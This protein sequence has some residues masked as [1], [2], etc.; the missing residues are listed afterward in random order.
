[1]D[2]D[3]IEQGVRL[4]LEGIGE[5]AG[6]EGLLDTP[7]RVADMYEEIFAGLDAGP[8][9]ALLRDLQRGPSGDG[10]RARHPALLGV[11]AP[12]RAVHGPRARRLHPR[13]GRAHLRAVEARARRRRVREAPAGPGAHDLA[14]R[15]HDRRA[16]RARPASSSSSRPSTCAC[17][18]AACKKPGSETVT[19]AV[20]GIFE[21]NAATRAEAMSL[22]TASASS[23]RVSASGAQS[24]GVA[25]RPLRALARPAARHGHPERHARLLLRRRRARRPRARRRRGA[26]A[27]SPRAPRSSTSAA[28][29]R[30]RA[31]SRCRRPA[32]LARV[33][34]VVG[35]FAGDADVPVSIDT[36]HAEVARGVRRG[37]REHHQRRL[38]LPR[39][40]RWSR[41][42]PAATPA[43]S[44]CTCSAS[45]G[46]CR[47][48]PRYDDVVARGRRLPARAGGGAR[49]GRASRAS[50]SRSIPG[51][52]FGK[53]LEHNLALLRRCRSSPR[54][55]TRLSS[56]CRASASSAR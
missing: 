52:G 49:G 54:S 41:S 11:R 43:S 51:I 31:P 46:R 47:T 18:C 3:K 6:R 56:A 19:S 39:P 5:D 27:S 37:G 38:R 32:E 21:R 16:P 50:G 23:R 45:R 42:P 48:S 8:G 34:P 2:R 26:S 33:R 40:A 22:I 55:A 35:R 10:A 14:D 20:R 9:R 1:M 25:L 36:R 53:T 29:R 30:A 28:S 44:S 15:R 12:P 24:A 7:R 4:I 17:R 13:Q